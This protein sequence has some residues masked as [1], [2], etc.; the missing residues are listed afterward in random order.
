MYITHSGKQMCIVN[1]HSKFPDMVEVQKASMICL[2]NLTTIAERLEHEAFGDISE[3][4]LQH[5]VNNTSTTAAESSQN[6]GGANSTQN[7]WRCHAPITPVGTLANTGHPRR[8]RAQATSGRGLG[9]R[10]L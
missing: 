7:Q 2:K 5:P 10:G 6:V 8:G 9:G 1:I 4:Q 3:V